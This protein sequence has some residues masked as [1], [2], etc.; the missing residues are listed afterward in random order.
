MDVRSSGELLGSIPDRS[1]ACEALITHVATDIEART[2]AIAERLVERIAFEM[3][4]IRED[5]DVRE[6][7]LDV[8]RACASLLTSMTRTWSDP[9]A[10]PPPEDALVWSRSL[11]SRKLPL[12]ALLRVFR[13]GQAGYRDVWHGA[14]GASGEAPEVIL[15]ALNATSAFTFTWVDAILEP[16]AAAYEEERGRSLRGA[17]AVRAETVEAILARAPVD[18][19]AASARL[20]YEL[21]RPHLAYIAWVETDAGDAARDRVEELATA[22]A[23]ALGDA[24]RRPLLLR[25]APRIVYGWVSHGATGDAELEA[26]RAMLADTSVRLAAG[27]RADGVEGFR[28]S[29]EEARRARRVARLL[30]RSASVTRYEDVAIAD[31]LTRDVDVARE[32]VRTTLGPLAVDDDASRRLISTLKIFLQ[33]GQSF[34][35]AARRL[36]I[37]QNTV[38][39]RVRRVLEL[40]GQQDAGSLVLRAAVELVPLLHSSARVDEH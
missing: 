26:A 5:E 21:D 15:E 25:V 40:T 8:A 38:A 33:E 32:V 3:D 7:L 12:D 10:V 18:T 1:P 36:G 30:H 16:L 35:K 17:H 31:L 27:R 14:L 2:D 28:A 39:Y 19:A 29:H 9:R 23:S 11:V 37:H 13:I 6:D 24:A 22:V 20:G 34:S 4:L